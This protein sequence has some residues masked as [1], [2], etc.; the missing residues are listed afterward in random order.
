MKGD[1]L[2]ALYRAYMNDIYHYLLKLCHHP[3]T[4]EDLVQETFVRAYDGLESYSGE[5]VRPWLFRTAHNAYIDWYRRESRQ[6]QTDPHLLAQA[7]Q[8]ADN[9]P[10]AEYL[11]REQIRS[12]L[13]ATSNLGE[14][15]RQALILRNYYGFSYQEIAD[16][17]GLSLANVKVTLYRARKVINEVMKDEL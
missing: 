10:E 8:T 6:I 15:S 7:S 11:Q 3:Q 9:G 14:T 16:I 5:R 12:W 2:E 17:L 13:A 4:A 1:S